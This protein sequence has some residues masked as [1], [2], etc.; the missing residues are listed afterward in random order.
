MR[1]LQ[2]HTNSIYALAFSP[3]GRWLAS[4]GYDG[5]IRLWNTATGQEEVCWNPPVDAWRAKSIQA[6]AFAPDGRTLVSG[7]LDG[8]VW[9][10]EVTSRGLLGQVGPYPCEVCSVA[11]RPDGGLLAIGFD[12]WGWS[13]HQ[14]LLFLNP[15]AGFTQADVFAH[16]F[17]EDGV[18][19]L[20]FAPDGARLASLHSGDLVR[21]WDL[22]TKAPIRNI[23]HGLPVR[24]VAF[25]PDGSLLATLP[26][27]TVQFWDAYTFEDRGT[28]EGHGNHITALSFSPE[29]RF[30]ATGG[31]DSTV[32]LWDVGSRRE[33]ARFDWDLGRIW[34][35]VFAPDGMTA[36]AAGDKPDI[37]LWDVA[38]V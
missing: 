19:D 32:R 2:G 37:L 7:G 26:A 23:R 36:A 11:C 20:S 17:S 18:Y 5:T 27:R 35:V 30:L 24:R 29:G 10:W 8:R 21:V 9:F 16:P 25:S 3:D 31:Y 12:A 6:L 4:G 33:C 22:R 28:L 34:A 14:T 15:H 38:D 1:L 13:S